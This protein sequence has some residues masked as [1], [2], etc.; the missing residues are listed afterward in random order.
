MVSHTLSRA[1]LA[2]RPRSFPRC[3]REPGSRRAE[4][5]GSLRAERPRPPR[6]VPENAAIFAPG[7]P[8]T[9]QRAGARPR[10]RFMGPGGRRSRR[11]A[12]SAPARERLR[13]LAAQ[14]ASETRHTAVCVTYTR[15]R[16]LDSLGFTEASPNSAPSCS[17][18]T[19]I[20]IKR[21]NLRSF[22]KNKMR[23]QVQSAASAVTS[24]AN[25]AFVC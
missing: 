21:K 15:T 4:A 11:V 19:S 23:L 10:N 2:G 17:R 24:G 16:I 18:M 8:R 25:D 1:R 7:A 20:D 5:R 6:H 14:G 9:P 13:V 3:R 12:R 22:V